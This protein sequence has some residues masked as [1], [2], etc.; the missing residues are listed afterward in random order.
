MIENIYKYALTL[1]CIGCTEPAELELKG[2]PIFDLK[3][4]A[5]ITAATLDEWDSI[6]GYRDP[7]ITIKFKEAE[8]TKGKLGYCR[9][10][11][12]N[13]NIIT[14]TIYVNRFKDI[15]QLRGIL[16]H[17]LVHAHLTCT[18]KDH[19]DDPSSIMYH[20]NI[21]ARELDPETLQKLGVYRE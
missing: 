4:A 18:D 7:T 17:E 9:H 20:G 5:F 13:K 10:K 2:G 3:E 6:V 1:L 8:S 19:S 15:R 16:L 12:V 14:L 21:T 11:K